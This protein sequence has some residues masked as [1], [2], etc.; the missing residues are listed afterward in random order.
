[1]RFPDYEEAYNRMV[2][3]IQHGF[4]SVDPVLKGMH[5]EETVHTGPYRNVRAPQRLD[6]P[7]TETKIEDSVRREVIEE[8]DIEEH[9]TFL[10]RL[11]QAFLLAVGTTVVNS[12]GKVT[13]AT[14]N[15]IDNQGRPPTWDTALEALELI[16]AD[17]LFD[18]GEWKP[19]QFHVHPDTAKSLGELSQVQE[20]RLDDIKRQKKEEYDATRRSRRLCC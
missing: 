19:P 10:Y 16:P 6:Q 15:V 2:R 4:L 5:V 8:A 20:R 17:E 1:M 7:M 12:I 18:E 9:T 3:D 13:H 11:A 14:G